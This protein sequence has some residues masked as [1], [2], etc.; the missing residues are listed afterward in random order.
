MIQQTENVQSAR[1]IRFKHVDQIVDMEY[2][3]KSYIKEAIKIE[4]SGEKVQFKETKEFNMPEEFKNKLA[5]S[6]SLI[7]LGAWSFQIL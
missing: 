3:L 5:A 6:A 2:V 7:C 1:Q 4:K